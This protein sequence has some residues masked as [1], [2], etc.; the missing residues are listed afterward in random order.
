MKKGFAFLLALCLTLAL[1]GCGNTDTPADGGN[2]NDPAGSETLRVEPL[3]D[4]IDVNSITDATL[5]VSFDAAALHTE[6]DKMTLDVKVCSY[7][8]YDAAE[9]SQLKV[10]DTIVADGREVVVTSIDT[11]NGVVINGGYEQD[12]LTLMGGDGGTLYAVG[13][14]DSKTFHEV[15]AVTLPVS[16]DCQLQDSADLEAGEVTVTA[17]QLAEYLAKDTESFLPDNTTVTVTG[18][19]I[20]GIS[21]VYR[22]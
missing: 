6:G 11:A 16:S 15:G 21:R 14:D 20:T 8:L 9:V 1:A 3:P 18:G 13:A 2:T 19:Q 5:P 17:D 7:E 10:G 22:P 12:G 4:S